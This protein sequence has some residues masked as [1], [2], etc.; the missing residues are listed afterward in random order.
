VQT[1]LEDRP[2]AARTGGVIRRWGVRGARGELALE[3]LRRRGAGTGADT[4]LVARTQYSLIR[5]EGLHLMRANLPVRAGDLVGLA[6]APGAGVGVRRASGATTR[7]RSGPSDLFPESFDRSAGTGRDQELLL[8]VEYVPGAKWTPAGRLTR[9]AAARAPAGRKLDVLE[10]QRDLTV[11]AVSV[12]GRIVVDLSS[13]KRRIARV[14]F[15]GNPAGRLESLYTLRVRFGQP[16]V[17][18]LWRNPRGPV[19]R[20]YMVTKRSLVPID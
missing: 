5:D 4:F 11:A 19:S 13:A 2:V 15:V 10:A 6:V 8:R 17:R 3:V 14:P 9:R 1:R 12:R 20:D 16:I 18:L 7:R